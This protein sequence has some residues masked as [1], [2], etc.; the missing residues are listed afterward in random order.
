MQSPQRSILLIEDSPDDIAILRRYLGRS[1]ER[2]YTTRQASTGKQAL[3]CCQDERFDCI[4]LDYN[5]PDMQGL[6]L[7]DTLRKEDQ[8]PFVPVVMLTGGGDETVAVQAMKRGAQ[9]YILKDHL[10]PEFLYHTIENAIETMAMQRQMAEQRQELARQHH[11]YQT[12]AEH[13]PDVIE[14]IDAQFRHLYAN[15]VITKITDVPVEAILGKTGREIGMQDELCT[16]WEKNLA[17]V[18]TTKQALQF[19]FT[20][21]S[22][23]G[24]SFFLAHLTPEF[25]EAGKVISVLA[26]SRD[27][28][29][30]RNLERRTHEALSALLMM[31]E[32]LVALEMAP[33]LTKEAP[34]SMQ[35]LADLTARVLDCEGTVLATLK[36]GS[37]TIEHIVSSS[38]QANMLSSA[39]GKQLSEYLP[40]IQVIQSLQAG[41]FVLVNVNCPTRHK[42]QLYP[43][44]QQTLLVPLCLRNEL[45]GFLVLYPVN[46]QHEYAEDEIALAAAVGKLAALVIERERLLHERE[47]ARAN[48][49]AARETTRQMDEFIGIISHELK[50]PLSSIKG[51]MQIAKLHLGRMQVEDRLNTL[52]PV[53]V[54]IQNALER[55]ERQVNIQNRL[56]SDL[57]D[58]SRIRTD[59]L[60]LQLDLCNLI[61][62][63][64]EIV[65]DQTRLTPARKIHFVSEFTEILVQADAQ[66]IGQVV[67]NYLSNAL[68]YSQISSSVEVTIKLA[69]PFVHV[70]VRDAGPG[71]SPEAQKHIWERFYRVP[72]VKVVSGSSVGLGLGLHICKTL[73]ERHG[74]NVGVQSV[75]GQGSTF[76]FTL[77]LA[78][79]S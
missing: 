66:R 41:K 23:T 11:A 65:E 70:A 1:N 22:A 63:V 58:A 27:I 59:K 56:I 78:D 35:Q 42:L 72:G 38:F 13:A 8:Q 75:L 68:K 18:F 44:Q 15:S 49:L 21:A 47:E 7:L 48:A 20:F 64:R 2:R 43:H 51:N 30:R 32:Q 67:N 54:N 62:L 79:K 19:E 9:D 28:T 50:T 76:W 12:L 55:A 71:L 61:I 16:L 45:I 39:Q 73:V 4:L 5:L 25:D 3:A 37:T 33:T 74:G 14:R 52:H 77:P 60:E 29:V 24:E 53:I 10:T 26:I 31:A 40:A 57:L 46:P 69:E 17:T 36:K 6:T 34:L